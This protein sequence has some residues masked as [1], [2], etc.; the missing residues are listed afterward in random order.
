MNIYKKTLSEDDRAAIDDYCDDL[1][2]SSEAVGLR[3]EYYTDTS[4][5]ARIDMRTKRHNEKISIAVRMKSNGDI[6]HK[7]YS[8]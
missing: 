7:T 6:I 2:A 3:E 5:G 8:L 1:I 4:A